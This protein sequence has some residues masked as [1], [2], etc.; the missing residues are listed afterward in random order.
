MFVLLYKRQFFY[1]GRVNN[2]MAHKNENE[3]QLEGKVDDSADFSEGFEEE[4]IE[5]S[6]Q[7][8]IKPSLDLKQIADGESI[9]VTMVE[10]PRKI[11]SDSLV[12]GS[13]WFVNVEKD[14]QVYSMVIPDSLRFSLLTLRKRHNWSSFTGKNINIFAQTGKINTPRFSG[15]AKTYKADIA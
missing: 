9:R 13:A 5:K 12:R 8:D 3:K 6:A 14:G 15:E 4:K 1:A 7:M 11:V 10:E 2:P